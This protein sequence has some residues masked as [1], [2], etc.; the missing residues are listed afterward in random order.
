MRRKPA[1]YCLQGLD[2]TMYVEAALA[3]G[4]EKPHGQLL[5]KDPL[6]PSSLDESRVDAPPGTTP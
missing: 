4:L 2:G 1:P 6:Q 5:Q 3:H